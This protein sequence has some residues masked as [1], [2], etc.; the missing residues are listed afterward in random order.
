MDKEIVENID[1]ILDLLETVMNA[2]D[3][4]FGSLIN[5]AEKLPNED[6]LRIRKAVEMLLD[7]MG[8]G[9]QEAKFSLTPVEDSSKNYRI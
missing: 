8:A 1:G 3:T 4:A 9:I 6:Q 5:I 7:H 2:F